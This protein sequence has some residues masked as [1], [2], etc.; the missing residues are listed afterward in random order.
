MMKAKQ[1]QLK[2]AADMRGFTLIELMVVIVI[3][4]I[5]AGMIVPRIMDRPR[6]PG[7]PRRV[8]TSVL[9]PKHSS[10]TSWITANIRPPSRG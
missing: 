4:G 8:L 2:R 6:R 9:S 5:L 10:S 3:L 7:G 1:M